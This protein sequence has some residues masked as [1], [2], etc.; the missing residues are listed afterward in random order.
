[1]NLTELTFALVFCALW[2]A[3]LLA[4]KSGRRIRD[5]YPFIDDPPLEL[6]QHVTDSHHG[7]DHFF[8]VHH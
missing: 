7:H 6:H 8:D 2:V 1:M 5:P 3:V 4:T